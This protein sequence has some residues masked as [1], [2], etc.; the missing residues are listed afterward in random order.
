MVFLRSHLQVQSHLDTK[1]IM[2][3]LIELSVTLREEC[4]LRVLDNRILRRIFGF[5]R[6]S[7]GD[8]RRLHNEDLHSLYRLSIIVKVIK[9]RKLRWAAHVGRMVEGRSA[10]KILTGNLQERNLS[11]GRGVDGSWNIP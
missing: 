8:W 1:K 9:Y 7:N 11:E 2:C 4:R 6:N 10:F 3:S 5:K